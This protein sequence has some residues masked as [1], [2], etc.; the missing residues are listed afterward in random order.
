MKNERRI[1][2]KNII[3]FISP[4]IHIFSIS[5]GFPVTSVAAEAVDSDEQIS[6]LFAELMHV[7]ALSLDENNIENTEFYNNEI[8][9]IETQLELLGVE[10]LDSA[11]VAIYS[12]GTDT[13]SSRGTVPQPA[14]TNTVKWY[15]ITN[16]NYSHNS[17]TYSVKQLIA[18]GYNPGGLLVTGKNNDPFYTE[19]EKFAN[20]VSNAFKL[21]IQKA[22]GLILIIQW[23]PYELLFSNTESNIFR[24]SYITHW[25]VSSIMF[26]YV[27]LSSQSDDEYRLCYFSNRL[28]LAVNAH[29]ASVVD[30]SPH[31]YS[32]QS[33]LLLTADNYASKSAAVDAYNGLISPYSYIYYYEAQSY[34]GAYTKRIYV[35]T[36]LEGPG[37]V[38]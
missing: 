18:V 37:Q 22:I 17:Q 11:D 23:T 3:T 19:Q 7:I 5:L 15:S 10:I 12:E 24:S 9:R 20:A 4:I 26:T 34:D 14:N 13:I 35:P 38:Y 8:S 6:V 21:Y 32:K 31:T 2:I 29:G 1:F 25:C 33:D 27:K 16:S 36:P 28:E 30:G